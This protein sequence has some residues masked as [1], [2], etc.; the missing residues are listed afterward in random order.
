M[1]GL[2]SLF[3]PAGEKSPSMS[4]SLGHHFMP[5]VLLT[6]AKALYAVD[7]LPPA[8][9]VTMPGVAFGYGE[10]ISEATQM[11]LQQAFDGEDHPLLTVIKALTTVQ[12]SH[13]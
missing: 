2:W 13:S 6:Y 11:A 4:P 5:G 1:R 10:R 3:E 8:W 12:A 9:L 7:P